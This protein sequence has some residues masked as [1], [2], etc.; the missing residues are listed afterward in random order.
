MQYLNNENA[1]EDERE[2]AQMLEDKIIAMTRDD[3]DGE[4]YEEDY[5]EECE[6]YDY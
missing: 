4:S 3:Y 6:N 2:F 5:D 1:T